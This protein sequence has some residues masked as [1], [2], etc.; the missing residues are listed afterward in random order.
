MIPSKWP[1]ESRVVLLILAVALAVR[2]YGMNWG[3]PFVYEEATPLK[4]AWAMWGWGSPLGVDLNP[5]FFNYPSLTIYL[6]FAAQGV[7]YLAMKLGGSVT[8]GADFHARYIVDPAPFFYVGRMISVLFG[9]GT[10]WM[11]YLA[12]RRLGGKWTA[13]LAAVLLAVNTFLISRSH[14][15]EVDLPLTF[16]AIFVLWL[17]LGLRKN[18]VLK[19]YLMAGAAIGL[20]AS[21]K[22]TGAILVLPLAAA[23]LC[24]RSAAQSAARERPPWW[25]AA[26]SI[27]AAAVVFAI[28]SPYVLLDS[29]TFAEDFATERQHMSLGHFGLGGS[30]SWVFYGRSLARDLMG[31]PCAILSLAGLASLALIQRKRSIWILGTFVVPY[32]LAV[33][34]WSMHADRY[35]LPVLPAL[36]LFAAAFIT[37]SRANP[38]GSRWPNRARAVAGAAV[39]LVLAV[40]VVAGY[41]AYLRGIRSDSRTTAARWIDTHI[42]GGSYLVVEP[43][44]PDIFGPQVISQ[45][46]PDVRK[47]VL[48]LKKGSPNYAVLPVPMFQVGPE[49]SE[50]FYDHALYENADYVVTTGAVRSR[51]AQEPARFRRQVAFY[52]SLETGYDRVAEFPPFGGGG[53]LVT[54]YKNRRQD[55]PF[56]KRRGVAPPRRLRHERGTPTGSEEL[57]YYNVGLNY[58]VFLYLDGAI[59]AYDLA[60]L[61]PIDRSASFK[62]LVLRKTHCLLL[63]ERGQEAAAYLDSMIGKAPTPGV[64]RQLQD[65]RNALGNPGGP[66]GHQ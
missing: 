64:R 41:P 24:A 18:P 12:G 28:T 57:F 21:T 13:A 43:Y 14:L 2:L 35:L 61:Y 5:H 59:A 46:S 56:S 52:D 50:V 8:S 66:P 54:I 26:A 62:N 42:P 47:K 6:Q 31:W 33:S 19:S 1:R 16:F 58:E 10:V 17:L 60:F 22:Y 25:F 49:R 34:T 4:K 36:L 44:G 7:L 45:V 27:L 39:A 55:V 3:L 38:L 65:L 9:V 30:S 37:D 29:G 11:T 15:I 32:L 53:S 20:A 48:E 23:H 51:Y 40:P 63:M